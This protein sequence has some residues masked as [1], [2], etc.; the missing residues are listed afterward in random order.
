MKWNYNLKQ[1]LAGYLFITP[2]MIGIIFFFLVPALFS[3]Y[4]M[5]TDW[6]YMSGKSPEFIGIDN[7][8]RLFNDGSFYRSIKNTFIF[9]MSVPVSMFIAFFIAYFLNRKV[10]FQ[11]LLRSMYFLPYV[12]N[13]VAIAFVWMLLFEPQNG[14]INGTLR[15]IGISDPPGWLSTTNTS[16]YAIVII[17]VWI[18]IGYNMIIY[19]AA[20]QE[21]SPELLEAAKIDGAKSNQIVRH[22]MLPLISPSSFLLLITGFIGAI[23]SF[24]IIQAITGGGPGDSTTVLSL[25]IYKSAFRYYEMGFA[26]AASWVLFAFVLILMLFNWYAQKNGCIT[27]KRRLNHES[28]CY[29]SYSTETSIR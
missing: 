24:G 26:S 12:M 6:T 15:A 5:F 4:L 28:N 19:L 3:F 18:M 10:Y 20:L 23:K 21:V 13:G 17:Q 1:K 25:Y 29:K 2:S 27:G 14:P 22:I 8:N 16:I 11:K 9:V 7:F